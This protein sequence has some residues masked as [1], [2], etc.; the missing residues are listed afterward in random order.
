MQ[1]SSSLSLQLSVQSSVESFVEYSLPSALTADTA[2]ALGT[3]ASNAPD[4]P[5]QLSQWSDEELFARIRAYNDETAFT[6]LYKRYDR[7][8][9]AYCLRATGSHDAAQDAFQSVMSA[10]F[11]NRHSFIGGNYAAWLFTIAR[12]H[13]LKLGR[14]AGRTVSLEAPH[15]NNEPQ[16]DGQPSSILDRTDSA[17]SEHNHDFLLQQSLSRAIDRL[18]DDLREAFALKYCQGF[19]HEE[20]AAMLNISVSLAKVRVFRAKQQ[21]RAML[22]SLFD[23]QS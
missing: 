14:R 17:T 1:F 22:A 4:L 8:L 16:A 18:P 20:L 21:L 6:T 7:R 10:V 12:H 13:V 15:A 3:A 9:Y 5:G 2:P 23:E 11:E 19:S